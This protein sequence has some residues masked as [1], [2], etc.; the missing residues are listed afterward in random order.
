MRDHAH[1]PRRIAVTSRSFSRHSVLRNELIERYPS[2]DITFNDGGLSWNGA[3]LIE[4]LRGYDHAI[5]SLERVDAAVIS[6][7]PELKVISKYGVGLDMLDLDAMEAHGV[8]LGWTPGVNR[9]AVA[10]LVVCFAIALLRHVP[11][12]SRQASEGSWRP[13]KGAQLSGRTIG[14]IGC[15]RVGKEVVQLLKTFGCRILAYDIVEYPKF[16]AKNNVKSVDLTELLRCSDIVTLH[17]PLDDSTRCILSAE[18]LAKMRPEAILINVARGGLVDEVALME[19]LSDGRLAAAGFDV[20][21]TE[22]PENLSLLALPNFLA[23]PHIGGSSEEA[24]LAM[25]RAAID[26]LADHGRPWEVVL[27]PA[28][29]GF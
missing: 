14:I 9:R 3:A 10:E 25:G 22:P 21:A 5:V 15:G 17:T 1:A 28:P 11:T 27:A 6:A 7:L 29:D 18:S 24:I 8:N 16:Y 23:T 20:F 4:Y 13:V 2:A 19:M 12:L 26:G